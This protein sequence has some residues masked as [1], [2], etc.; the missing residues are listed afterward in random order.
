[1]LA[2]LAAQIGLTRALEDGLAQ[3]AVSGAARTARLGVDLDLRE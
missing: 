2:L 3:H 1:M